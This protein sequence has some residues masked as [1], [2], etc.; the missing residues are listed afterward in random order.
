MVHVYVH[1][2]HILVRNHEKQHRIQHTSLQLTSDLL[3]WLQSSVHDADVVAH[4]IGYQVCLCVCFGTEML[5]CQ[6]GLVKHVTP[7]VGSLQTLTVA[8]IR[9]FSSLI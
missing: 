7:T 8:S 5:T 2:N 4:G 3:E 6:A 9:N 1:Y